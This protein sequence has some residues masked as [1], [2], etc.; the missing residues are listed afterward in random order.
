MLHK[1]EEYNSTVE[2]EDVFSLSSLLPPLEDMEHFYTYNG[3]LTTP[4]CSEA[5][6]W[7][8]FPN[9]LPISAIQVS[10]KIAVVLSISA[11]FFFLD[12]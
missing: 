10:V 6:T 9:A 2:I 12:K 11:Y 5:V 7:I 8:I 3:S 4:P 1:V